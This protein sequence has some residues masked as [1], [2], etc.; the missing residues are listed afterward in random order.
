MA[1][2]V[3]KGSIK[4]PQGDP[5]A[6]AQLPEGGT[7]GQ[8]L[9]KTSG[10]EAW[11]DVPE[12]DLT[13][14]VKVDQYSYLSSGDERLSAI[15]VGTNTAVGD[16]QTNYV[17]VSKGN[18]T[19]QSTSGSNTASFNVIASYGGASAALSG[20][21]SAN[22]VVASENDHAITLFASPETT[23]L[24]F[25]SKQIT[26]ITD[27][28][29]DSPAG[30][31]LVTDKAVADYV[32]AHGMPSVVPISKGGTGATTAEGAAL[33]VFAH[34]PEA[35]PTQAGVVKTLSDEDFCAYMGMEY[36]PA[37]WS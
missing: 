20:S 4:G 26:S 30:S 10:G 19:M 2:W 22:V 34:A 5:G 11:A 29:A 18:I 24:G 33:M 12:P 14:V 27:A 25:D 13:G 8:V 32:D 31:A 16:E 6:D 21:Q 23:M 1:D 7:D 17:A 9:T 36:D 37:D 28:I 3:L 15:T 35:S